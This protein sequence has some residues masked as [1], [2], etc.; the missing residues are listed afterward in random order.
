MKHLLPLLL[1]AAA[2][3]ALMAQD[4]PAPQFMDDFELTSGLSIGGVGLGGLSDLSYD[5]KTGTFVAISDD[6]GEFGP[7]RFYTLGLTLADG[8]FKGLDIKSMH[9]L[10]APGGAHFDQ[11]GADP[12]GIALDPA[13]DRMFWSSERDEENA[14]AI[15]VAKMDGTDSHKLDL[16][17][18]FLPDASGH[19][20]VYENLGHEGL[21]LS[22]DGKMLV[23]ATENA[24]QQDGPK[25]TLE[26]GSPARLLTFDLETLKPGAQYL[27]EVDKIPAAPP[28][29]GDWADN[30]ISAMAA[31]PDGRYV[32]LERSW[33]KGVGDNIRA[34]LVSLDGATD[35]SGQDKL[36]LAK[37]TPVQKTLWF[38]LDKD[39]NPF[40]VP[41]DNLEAIE[42]G[43]VIDGK[44][45][46]ILEADNNF[47]SHEVNQFAWFAVDLPHS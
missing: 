46:L 9:E 30:G 11:K 16:P 7:V 17:A 4:L 14:P 8:K 36:D 44:Q 32:V 15:Y 2:P 5:A 20:G 6:K 29:A 3:S 25:A 23:A 26:A 12:E 18:A 19:H 35:V 33:T 13:H 31:L 21:T 24:L 45:S 28:K 10:M 43:P 47:S 38:Q 34:Y 40:K 39:H 27:Y 42:F 22:G 1:L 41:V 37:D